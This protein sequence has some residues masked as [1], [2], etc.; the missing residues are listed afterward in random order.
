MSL[1]FPSVIY[2]RSAID[3]SYTA[4]SF[5]AVDRTAYTF[6]GQAFG[7]A[8]SGRKILVSISTRS[9]SALPLALSTVTIGG[10]AATILQ[11]NPLNSFN[12]HA[13]TIADVPSGTTGDV[14]VTFVG[15]VINCS[16]AV[17]RL[18]G[19]SGTVSTQ[20]TDIADPFTVS[21]DIPAGGAAF[22]IFSTNTTE[23]PTM[24]NLTKDASS[25]VDAYGVAFASEAFATAQ[26]GLTI[27]FTQAVTNSA[28]S[29]IT[30]GPA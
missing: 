10:V 27:G 11:E 18:I 6:A 26:T 12:R 24:T 15:G 20:Y 21:A 8:A 13:F 3:L 17:Y 30:M 4:S 1:I 16:V 25:I 9:G 29:F 19:A 2:R 14:V 7:A 23:A 5:D 28:A 22:G